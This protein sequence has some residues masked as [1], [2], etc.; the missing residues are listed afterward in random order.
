M[1]PFIYPINTILCESDFCERRIMIEAN[2]KKLM[3]GSVQ[4]KRYY[5]SVAILIQYRFYSQKSQDKA[6][7]TLRRYHGKK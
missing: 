3:L 1:K 6:M 7:E 2:I 5:E 4:S